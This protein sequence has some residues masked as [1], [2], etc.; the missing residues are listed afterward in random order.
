LGVLLGLA[1]PW[2]GE[3]QFYVA[4]KTELYNFMMLPPA[5]GRRFRK[6]TQQNVLCVIIDHELFYLLE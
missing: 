3:Q 1:I 4:V 5:K 2:H 6:D